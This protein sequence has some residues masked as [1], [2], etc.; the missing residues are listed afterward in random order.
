MDV[1]V[2]L[3]VLAAL[4]PGK[5]PPGTDWIGDRVSPRVSLNVVEKRNNLLS[6]RGIEPR[7][8]DPPVCSQSLYRLSQP[9]SNYVISDEYL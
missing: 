4:P 8:I 9:D 1:S 7:F 6:S 3:H 2:Q 5:A